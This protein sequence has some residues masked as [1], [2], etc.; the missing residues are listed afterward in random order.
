MLAGVIDPE[1]QRET[2]QLLHNRSEKE[3]V[4]NTADPLEYLLVL[5]RPVIKVNGKPQQPN[6]GRNVNGPGFRNEGWSHP[7]GKEP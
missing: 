4:W 1:Y 5:P 6:S 3:Y 2:D 7:S